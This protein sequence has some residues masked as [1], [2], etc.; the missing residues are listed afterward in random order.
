MRNTTALETIRDGECFSYFSRIS[1]GLQAA[2]VTIL[3][4]AFSPSRGLGAA[5]MAV[6][7][8]D[9]YPPQAA[10]CPCFTRFLVAQQRMLFQMYTLLKGTSLFPSS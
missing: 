4:H 6:F 8:A 2:A 3:V 9:G 5:V 1:R 7:V 10:D